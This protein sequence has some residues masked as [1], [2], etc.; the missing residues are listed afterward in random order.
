[1]V[2]QEGLVTVERGFSLQGAGFAKLGD[3]DNHDAQEDK[4]D[5]GSVTWESDLQ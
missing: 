3:E 1:M 5:G 2:G 4:R